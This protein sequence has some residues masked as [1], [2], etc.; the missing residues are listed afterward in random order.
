MD[1]WCPWQNRKQ[2]SSCMPQRTQPRRTMIRGA[3]ASLSA[4]ACAYY[5]GV[6]AHVWV[7]ASALLSTLATTRSLP[8]SLSPPA[9]TLATHLR[10]LCV[11]GG[12]TG[13][14]LL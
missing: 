4:C 11:L 1:E 10:V 9:C 5:P 3:T 8:L 14:T 7:R 13:S 6:Y 12:Y 2:S